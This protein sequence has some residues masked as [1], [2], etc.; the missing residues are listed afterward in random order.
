[1]HVCVLTDDHRTY[2]WGKGTKG[3]LSYMSE[4]GTN[5]W[6]FPTEIFVYAEDGVKVTNIRRIECG[7]LYTFALTN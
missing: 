1:M 5:R 6:T 7:S 4:D 2:T 3:Q